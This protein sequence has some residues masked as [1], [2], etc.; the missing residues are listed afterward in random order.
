MIPLFSMA[1]NHL[2]T[3]FLRQF[4][5]SSNF[6]SKTY[7]CLGMNC[8]HVCLSCNSNCLT[9]VNARLLL[10]Y[11]GMLLVC[12]LFNTILDH[13]EGRLHKKHVYKFS[14]NYLLVNKRNDDMQCIFRILYLSSI[15]VRVQP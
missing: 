10:I 14:S 9:F 2:F 12:D 3:Y 1:T 7:L 15:H 4:L 6:E 13:S 8:L 11:I 5:E